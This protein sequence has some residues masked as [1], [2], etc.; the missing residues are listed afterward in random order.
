MSMYPSPRGNASLEYSAGGKETL[1][2]L[3]LRGGESF[4]S[5][6]LSLGVAGKVLSC[7]SIGVEL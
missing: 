2:P 6:G 7:R 4:V 3:N 5:P 1:R